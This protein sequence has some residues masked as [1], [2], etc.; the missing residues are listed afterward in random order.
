MRRGLGGILL[1]AAMFCASGAAAQVGLNQAD[2]SIVVRSLPKPAAPAVEPD[3]LVI[4]EPSTV[5]G[6]ARTGTPR[7]ASAIVVIGAPEIARSA[8]AEAIMPY[9]GRDLPA[10]ALSS[11]ASDIA[12]GARKAGYPFASAWVEPQTMADGILRVKLDAGTLSAVRVIGANNALADRLLTKSLVTGRAVRRETLER[13]I[14][15]VGDIPG[16]SVV[17]S[18]Y[19]RQDGFGILLVTIKQDRV[20]AYA[21]VDN[22]GSTEVGPIR[23]T[24]LGSLRGLLQPGDELGLISAQTPFQPSEFFFVRGRYTS[25]LSAAGT[26]LSV[27]GS[28]GRA[29]PG[30]SLLPLRVIGESVDGSLSLS[31]PLIRGQKK[32]M[33]AN[34]E[35]RGLRSH[36]TLLGSDL[37]DDRLATLTGAL[38]GNSRFGP[39]VLRGSV[40]L[41]AGLPVPG[42]THEGDLRT[43]RSDGD[44]RFLTVNYDL[45]WVVPLASRFSIA[46]SSQAQIASRP[47]LA[48]MEIGV[49]GPSFGRGYD[50]AE[51]TGDNGILGGA[52]LR[53]NLGRVVRNV[54]DRAQIYGAVDGGY[55]GNLRNG[56]G[57]GALLSTAAGLRLGRGRLDGMLE[58]ALPLN[59]DRFDTRNRQPRISFRLSRVF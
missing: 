2:P 26:T 32:S 51:R 13:A 35:L 42:V 57:G 7:I 31:M 49:G 24:V 53:M 4:T 3:P 1:A 55:V 9:I 50:Y 12:N 21:Q 14:L 16:V 44:A 56:S 40:A 39:G 19:I 30:A 34:V 15:L 6:L 58:V 38:N 33:W 37:R 52:E 45:E 23:S 41:V 27:S 47:L 36:Q 18:R 5:I 43:S 25:P 59:E 29:H 28:Y 10:A 48:T 46:V 20:G 54:I 8:F 17:E 22:R 11:L